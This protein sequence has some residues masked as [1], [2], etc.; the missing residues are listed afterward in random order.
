MLYKILG[1]VLIL[2]GLVGAVIP[3]MP[4]IPFLLVGTLLLYKDRLHELRK[5]LP[6]EIPGLLAG[7][8]SAFVVGM[9]A[10][11]HKKVADDIPLSPGK[12]LLDIGT[13]PGALPIE[14]AKR[15][16]DSKIIGIDLSRSMIEI[17]ERNR[18]R[19]RGQGSGVQNLEFKVMD[20][21]SMGFADDSLDMVI[22]T[23]SMHHWKDPVRVFN[24]IYRCLKPG[25]E[26]WIYDGYGN[27]SNE[28]INCQLNKFL[29]FLPTPRMARAILRLHGY[30]QN[31]Y[32]TIIQNSVSNSSFK[33]CSLEE[34][35]VM[36]RVRLSKP[37]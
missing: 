17:A 36:M 37:R 8:Y 21:K 30:T 15:F 2:L 23:G 24:E 31:E 14:I 19:V 33:T 7:M 20:A 13:G 11:Y 22:S 6:E 12:V 34:A 27:A 18:Q 10:P 4:C 3:I 35:G 26:A 5:S 25:C 28:N 29:G 32:D 9:F 1:I 16:P